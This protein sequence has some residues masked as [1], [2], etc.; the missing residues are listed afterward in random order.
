MSGITIHGTYNARWSDAGTPGAHRLARAAAL[1]AVGPPGAAQ[2]T[3]LG[4]ARVVDLR[5]DTEGTAPAHGVPVVRVPLYRLPDGPPQI[6]ALEAVYDF[7]LRERGTELTRAVIAIATAPGRVLV[8]CTAGKDR[9]GLVVALAM[10]AAGH[11]EA[12]VVTDY[13]LSMGVVGTRRA[14]HVRSVLARLNLDPAA[15]RDALRLHLDSPPA[16]IERVLGTIR[17][18]GGAAHYLVR[19]GATPVHLR[20]LR[21]DIGASAD[22]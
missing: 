2:L 16:A 12:A 10:L 6:G 3:A 11:T 22:A 5:E 19:H 1:D 15:Y 21:R 14:D 13:S 9:T 18:L 17:S 20:A 7:L 4:V 8:H